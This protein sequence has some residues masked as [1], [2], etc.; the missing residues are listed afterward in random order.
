MNFWGCLSSEVPL[1]CSQ[2]LSLEC[3]MHYYNVS[4]DACLY[5]CPPL[6]AA[7]VLNL[8]INFYKHTGLECVHIQSSYNS[9]L[10]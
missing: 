2:V 9:C 1:C 6:S 8:S 4:D 3:F 7:E 5:C 10:G